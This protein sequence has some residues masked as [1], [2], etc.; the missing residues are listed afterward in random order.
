MPEGVYATFEYS[1]Q[2][3]HEQNT[4]SP[5][6]VI[7]VTVLPVNDPPKGEDIE[8]EIKWEINNDLDGLK[9]VGD[10]QDLEKV[11]I[12]RGKLVELSSNDPD[13]SFSNLKLYTVS[14][15]ITKHFSSLSCFN[16]FVIWY[17]LTMQ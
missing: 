6:G 13:G 11:D 15:S 8:I 16:F 7:S 10:L 4:K 14:D 9:R 5:P 12:N 3:L 2:K 1:F 17:L